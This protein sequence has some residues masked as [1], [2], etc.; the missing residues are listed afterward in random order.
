MGSVPVG[1]LGFFRGFPNGLVFGYGSDSSSSSSTVL[2]LERREFVKAPSRLGG[3][4]EGRGVVD[5]K[6][7]LALKSHSE[8]E[9]R[10]RER[11]NHHL[12][13]LRSMI[14]CADKVSGSSL[15]LSLC[16]CAVLI[17]LPAFSCVERLH[18]QHRESR[19]P[20]VMDGCCA[21]VDRC[22]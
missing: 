10:R 22:V 9:R 15:S 1:D 8:A 7:A 5:A 14:P 16:S 6:T 21:A 4:K 18:L 19:S 20:F 17:R 2:D 11:I 3:K 12:A 13:V